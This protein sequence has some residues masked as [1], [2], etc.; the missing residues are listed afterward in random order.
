MGENEPNPTAI[1][2]LIRKIAENYTLP[3]YTI[4]PTYSICPKHGYIAGKHHYC[5][6]CD[7]EI[8]YNKKIVI[9]ARR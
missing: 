9:K 2:K 5:P 1:K 8:G 3:Y 6:T 4:T 7:E